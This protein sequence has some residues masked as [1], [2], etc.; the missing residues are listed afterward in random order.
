[1]YSIVNEYTSNP[2]IQLA[3]KQ[4]L[5]GLPPGSSTRQI[6]SKLFYW[7][8]KNVSFVQDHVNVAKY[9]PE[10]DNPTD[11]ELLI[12]PDLLLQ[13]KQGDCDCI[14]TLASAMLRIAGLDTKFVTIAANSQQPHVFSHVY[15]LVFDPDNQVWIPFDVSHG[16]KPDWEYKDV[17]RR[18]TWT[19]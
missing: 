17:T 18:Y 6:I 10:V 19:D 15:L 13:V 16:N 11:V 3:T 12:T 5:A 1:M 9:L 14:S 4:A 8:K 7:I 2:D